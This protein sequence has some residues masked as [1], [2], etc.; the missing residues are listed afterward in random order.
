MQV[1]FN[2]NLFW[3]C[4]FSHHLQPFNAAKLNLSLGANSAPHGS[5]ARLSIGFLFVGKS[6]RL[7][8]PA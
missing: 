8:P 6:K 7:H 3:S 5:I 2:I 4:F 1:A